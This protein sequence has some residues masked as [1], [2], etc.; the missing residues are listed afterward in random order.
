M[1]LQIMKELIQENFVEIGYSNL[2]RWN[3]ISDEYKSLG[4]IDTEFKLDGMLYEEPKPKSTFNFSWSLF[5]L[6]MLILAVVSC[7]AYIF[8]RNATILKLEIRN[9][10]KMQKE[11]EKSEALYRSVIHASP[12]S[13]YIT[14]LEGNLEYLSPQAVEMFGYSPEEVL[15]QTVI[16]FIH[17]DDRQKAL[18]NIRLMFTGS[19]YRGGRI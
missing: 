14:D 12:D 8:Y 16:M 6:R 11:L 10:E 19:F 15:N 4:L 5:A 13:I 3:K 18:D 9:R 2:S 7:I 17:P 1:R